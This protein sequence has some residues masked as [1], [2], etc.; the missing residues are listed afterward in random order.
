PRQCLV[1]GGEACRWQLIEQIYSYTPSCHI[2]N[3]YGPTETTV[4]V[5]T[6]PIN[7]VALQTK[8]P[9]QEIVPIG[10]PI[11]NT[12]VYLLNTDLQPVPIGVPGELYIGG[13][14]VARG[15][16]NRPQLTAER[17]LSNPFGQQWEQ[18]LSESMPL[19]ATLYKTGDLARYRLDG[20]VD[21]LGRA[22]H[23]VKIRGYRIELG[24]IESAIRQHS[25]VQEAVVIVRTAQSGN[26]RLVAY[27]VPKKQSNLTVSALRDVLK[28][29][30][31]DYMVPAA[32]VLLKT[33]PLT[34]NGK[35]D[36]QA[37]PAPELTQS[38]RES[39]FVAPITEAEQTLA[40]IWAETLGVEKIGIHDN[41][42]ELGGDSI[43]S[44]QIV[45]RA[46]QAG[47]K[48][49][50]KQVFENQTVAELAAV[51]NTHQAIQAEQGLVVGNVPLTPIQHWFFEQAL[52]DA[53][54]WNQSIL[55]KVHQPLELR[56]LEQAVQLLL[57]H[58]DVLRLRFVH[59]DTGWQQYVADPDPITP[60][61]KIDL[62]AVAEAEQSAAISKA[63]AKLQSSL[64]LA[65]GPLI[66]VAYFDLGI[67]RPGRL[68]LIIHHL[69][70]DGVS[71]RILLED[72]QIA[73][74]QLSQGSAIQLPPKTTSFQYWAAQLCQY[75]QSETLRQELDYWLSKSHQSAVPVD[76]PEGD[77]TLAKADTVCVTLSKTETQ[78][79]L[80]EV[81]TAYKTQINDVLLTAIVQAFGQ[82]TGKYSLLI[83]LEG[84]GREDLFEDVDLSRTVGWFTTI[85]PVILNLEQPDNPGDA[86]KTIKEQ[87]REIPNRGIGYG[88]L[89]Y[90]SGQDSIT[91]QQQAELR[92][93]YLGQTD[94]ALQ[95][96][97]LFASAH[98]PTGAGR[99]LK[100]TRC[101]LIDIDG[102]VADGQLSVTW[103]YSKAVHQPTT[104]ET[105]AKNFIKAL[106]S[107]ITHCQSPEAGGYTP[108]DFS[109]A[110][111]D[112]QELDQFL[113][114]LK[115]KS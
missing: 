34:P 72:L 108:S 77:N 89:R 86:L 52:P 66:C 15:Y 87:L 5:L 14:S 17:F 68:L 78:A 84:H 91:W 113:A 100:G 56:Q 81:P 30:L 8:P 27:I 75:G 53:H 39:P 43:L 42:F 6:Y 107:L 20:T 95:Q 64:S 65:S 46:N 93:N 76:F 47:L 37:L 3:H 109:E 115:G 67:N 82:W 73:Q 88:A 99:S 10:H 92:F 49:T 63:A 80:K 57:E 70:I 13:A 12:Q 103:T 104:I 23:Q 33:L 60:L 19:G 79:L 9:Q 112:Q 26:N 97:S 62:S 4:G 44:I 111:L 38:E 59:Q 102:I 94:Q 36:R 7:Q 106:R 71:W 22:D 69:A 83:D 51:A 16:L 28:E 41:F 32:F 25:M 21:F 101:Y 50:P 29:R 54:H 11:A 31:P 55:L 40:K 58:H 85:F 1:L 24:E 110:N 96:S 90:L 105:L 35:L 48:L 18:T 74:Q 114:K 45:A 98:E 2:F 61:T